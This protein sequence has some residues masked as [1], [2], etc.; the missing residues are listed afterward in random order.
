MTD[1]VYDKVVVCWTSGVRVYSHSN[2]SI[3][4]H[5]EYATQA[6]S[7]NPVVSANC[8]DQIQRLGM[9][10]GYFADFYRRN[11]NVGWV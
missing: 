1:A 6:Y 8:L 9:R 4:P 10:L 11:N 3:R 2:V 7:A 5:L